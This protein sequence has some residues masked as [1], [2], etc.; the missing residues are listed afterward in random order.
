M[1]ADIDSDELAEWIAYEQVTGPL[2]PT[3]GD[4]LHGIRAA[5][6]ANTVAA[7]GRKA[8]PRD[9]IPVWDQAPPSPEDMFDTVRTM[10][11][12]LGG[13]DHTTGGNGD[14]TQ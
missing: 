3:R 2:G 10:T 8:T 12:L 4:V 9:L 1:L 11:A 6:T 13:T 5:V 7:R 14:D